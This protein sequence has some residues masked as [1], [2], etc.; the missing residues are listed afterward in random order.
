MWWNYRKPKPL[1]KGAFSMAATNGV[2][3]VPCFITMRDTDKL[4]E[5]GFKVQEY[6]IH[7]GKPIYPDENKSIAQNISYMMAENAAEWQQ[8]YERF[9]GVPLRYDCHEQP[10]VLREQKQKA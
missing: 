6:T 8:T 7:I 1:K 10:F 3:V 4:D 9:Y 5:N 2:P